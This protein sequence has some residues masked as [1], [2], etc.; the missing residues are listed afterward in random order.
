MPA[1]ITVAPEHLLA[2]IALVWL[3]IC[4]REEM[5][6]EVGSLVKAPLTHGAFV[7]RLL[8]M[9][10]L[11]NS[12]GSRLAE[13]LATLGTFKRFLFGMNVSVISQVIL[14]PKC[15]TTNIT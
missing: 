3:V 5:R 11:M 2:L 7:R 6:L 13:T 9:Q 4:V 14:S 10:D 1:Q 8:H 15:F 12:Q